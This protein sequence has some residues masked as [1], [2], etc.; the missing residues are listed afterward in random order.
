MI[1]CLAVYHLDGSQVRRLLAKGE[2]KGKRLGHEWVVLE[3][4]YKRK[5]KPKRQ[6]NVSNLVYIAE[7]SMQSIRKIAPATLHWVQLRGI[8]HQFELRSEDELCGTLRW[9]KA[10]GSLASSTS[11]D[12][13][14]TFKRVGFLNP[15]V[16]VRQPGSDLDIAIFKPGWNGSGV[17]EFPDGRRFQWEHKDFWRLEWIFEEAGQ[18]LCRFKSKVSSLKMKVRVDLSP[19]V[20]NLP[21]AS[22]VASLGMYLLVLMRDDSAAASASTATVA[23]Y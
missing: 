15:R 4:N 17:L 22:L 23:V 20:K 11:D 10:F 6:S 2:I 1:E 18:E 3:L 19:S 21:E 16:T 5:R 9:E 12:G 14:W 7:V 13:Q 8:R